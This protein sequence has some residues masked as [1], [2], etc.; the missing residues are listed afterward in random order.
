M[1]KDIKETLEIHNFLSIKHIKWEIEKFNIITGDM[2]AGKSLCIKLTQFFEDIIV[3]LLIAPFDEFLEYLNNS[4]S[5]YNFLIKEKFNG[6]FSF[7]ASE[8]KTL[9]SFRIYYT[10]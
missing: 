10:F 5:F 2:A 7:M 1:V 9:P 3:N 8:N 6:I 4:I